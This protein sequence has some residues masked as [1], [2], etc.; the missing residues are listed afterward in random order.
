M[1]EYI[2]SWLLTGF[3]KAIHVQLSDKTINVSMPEIFGQDRFLKLF[4][5]FDSE[6]FAIG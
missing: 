2:F 3:V 1:T 6:L 4:Y 5:V